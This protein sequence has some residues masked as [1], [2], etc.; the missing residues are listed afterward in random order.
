MNALVLKEKELSH[1][2]EAFATEWDYAFYI[3]T[4]EMNIIFNNLAR[5]TVLSKDILK[6]SYLSIE[7][8]ETY[9]LDNYFV[10]KNT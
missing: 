8:P 10:I 9:K 1:L 5:Y 4:N 2:K 3:F 6:K 7:S